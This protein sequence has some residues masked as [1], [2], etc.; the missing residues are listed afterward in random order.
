M[1]NR[2]T[3]TGVL[4]SVLL[5]GCAGCG[6]IATN[7]AI[8]E[9]EMQDGEFLFDGESPGRPVVWVQ[10]RGPRVTDAGLAHL[11]GLPQL[12]TLDLGLHAQVTDAGLKHLKG[13]TQLQTLKL[14]F[15]PQVTDAGLEHLKGLIQLKRL[16]LMG[17]KVTD[18]G[19]SE[20]KKALPNVEIIK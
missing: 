4:V 7:N 12:Q 19:V 3:Q 16:N 17:T 2:L 11:K 20:L 10:F 9:I 15:C 8:A 1:A 18:A 13:L 6:R 5:L 14:D